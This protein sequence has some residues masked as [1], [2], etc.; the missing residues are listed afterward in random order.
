[1]PKHG[2]G[3][4]RMSVRRLNVVAFLNTDTDDRFIIRFDDGLESAEAARECVC[5]WREDMPWAIP[6]EAA[7]R[8]LDGLRA[9][10]D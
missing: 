4:E 2:C 1:M 3:Y 8:M 9:L 5:R 6:C 7:E 10:T